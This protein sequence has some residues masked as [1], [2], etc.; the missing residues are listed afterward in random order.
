MPRLRVHAFSVS[1]DGYGAGPAQDVDHPLGQGGT[2]LHEWIFR[3]RTF[4]S[5]L[6][7]DGGE[8]GVDDDFTAF[9]FDNIGAWIV[10]RNMFGPVRGPWPDDVW[11]GWWGKNP[12]FHAPVFVLTHHARE[13]IEME[14]GT[15]FHFVTGGTEA[16]LRMASA[17]AGGKDVRLGGG[18]GTVRQYLKARLIDELHVAI[19]PAILGSGESLLAGLDLLKLG[20]RCKKHLPGANATHV[21]LSK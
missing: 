11:R 19:T 7:Q 10:G 2:A 20:Y 16:A 1:L 4:R 14:G 13:S 3:T 18:V 15:A 9:G 5:L 12:P 17:A 6:G 8:R 21:V